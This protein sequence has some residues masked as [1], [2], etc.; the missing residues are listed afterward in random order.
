MSQR[1]SDRKEFYHEIQ[2]IRQ[3][4]ESVLAA[5]GENMQT[6]QQHFDTGLQSLG[7]SD[8]GIA[9]FCKKAESE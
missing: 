1:E 6:L 9:S 5:L 7:P 2:S 4:H 8:D 3:G